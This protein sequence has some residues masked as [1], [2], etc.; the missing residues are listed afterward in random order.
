MFIIRCWYVDMFI[1][2]FVETNAVGAFVGY[3]GYL[4]EIFL[5]TKDKAT[6]FIGNMGCKIFILFVMILLLTLWFVIYHMMYY[7]LW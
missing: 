6:C 1:A 2:I 5:N 4:G 7:I 3:F